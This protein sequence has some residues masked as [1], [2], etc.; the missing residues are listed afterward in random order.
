MVADAK[1][2]NMLWLAWWHAEVDSWMTCESVEPLKIIGQSSPVQS[3]SDKVKECAAM[4][5]E[6]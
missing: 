4:I 6:Q 2:V 1:Q 3:S 5:A